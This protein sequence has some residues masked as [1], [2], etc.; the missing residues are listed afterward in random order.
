MFKDQ[1]FEKTKDLIIN[2][3][4]INKHFEDYLKF[5][6]FPKIVL[7]KKLELL[8]QYYF[9]ILQKDII[10]R[11]DVREKNILEALGI[12]LLTNS[13][14]TVSVTSLANIYNISFSLA[15]TY[16]NYF[17]EA[18]LI[19]E[20]PQ[21]SYSLKTQEKAFKKIYSIDTGLASAVSFRFSEDKGRIL[22]NCVLLHLLRQESEIFYYKTRNKKEVDFL[23]KRNKHLE[24]IQVCAGLDDEKTAKREIDSLKEAMDELNLKEGIILTEGEEKT[25]T[26]Q[27][28]KI[29]IKSLSRWL[30]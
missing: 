15:E 27:K 14:K 9:D 13:A 7:T 26:S 8:K 18:F 21:F 24:L 25:L 28:S 11:Y 16:L 1:H 22:E 30:L 23:V 5:G 10:S 4:M 3:K 19:L 20:L 29:Y 2:E 6:G 12:F 17:K